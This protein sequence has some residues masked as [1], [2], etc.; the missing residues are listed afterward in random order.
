[1]YATLIVL[2][3]FTIAKIIMIKEGK[4]K[5]ITILPLVGLISIGLI[6]I[7]LIPFIEVLILS[8]RIEQMSYSQAVS[9]SLSPLELFTLILPINSGF[10]EFIHV[11]LGHGLF[12][13]IY[14]GIIPFFLIITV[15]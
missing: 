3:L 12:K 8:Y 1:L 11:G 13:G 2:F 14:L 4:S 15:L 10:M 6:F 7:Q 9:W 5:V